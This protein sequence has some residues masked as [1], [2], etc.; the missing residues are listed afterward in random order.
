MPCNHPE[1]RRASPTTRFLIAEKHLVSRFLEPCAQGR[2]SEP[3]PGRMTGPEGP[4]RF[5]Y[6]FTFHTYKK[7]ASLAVA[8]FGPAFRVARF[9]AEQTF[10][11]D[12][13]NS[14]S[15]TLSAEPDFRP[16]RSL[17]IVRTI[18]LFF[19]FRPWGT[20]DCTIVPSASA[21]PWSECVPYD[22]SPVDH[23]INKRYAIVAHRRELCKLKVRRLKEQRRPDAVR[24]RDSANRAA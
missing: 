11:L 9:S 21:L 16:S 23:T 2:S 17:R 7:V 13:I 5:R 24:T 4:D 1:D 6:A 18:C 14:A 8:T 15:G 3:L 22:P 20:S 10:S 19:P 12:S